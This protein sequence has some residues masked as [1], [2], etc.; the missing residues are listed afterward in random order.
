MSCRSTWFLWRF[1]ITIENVTCGTGTALH[2]HA[3][4][5]L[6][7]Y[8][9]VFVHFDIEVQ[10]WNNKRINKR[11]CATR[12]THDKIVDAL[13]TWMC[14]PHLIS[15][16]KEECVEEQEAPTSHTILAVQTRIAVLESLFCFFCQC[17]LGPRLVRHRPFYTA[18]DF[19][20]LI[21][22]SSFE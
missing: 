1:P 5:R 2:M 15:T 3:R 8:D 11:D 21:S 19:T 12:R 17:P 20:F 6:A 10:L 22:L 4:T 9:V 14:A 13:Y 18:F 7:G 16:A